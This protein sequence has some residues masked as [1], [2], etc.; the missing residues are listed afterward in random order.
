MDSL[1][2]PLAALLVIVVPL[3]VAYLLVGLQSRSKCQ[4]K[5]KCLVRR[6]CVK[7]PAP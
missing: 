6:R 2:E 7:H 5:R 4:G 3:W 1:L